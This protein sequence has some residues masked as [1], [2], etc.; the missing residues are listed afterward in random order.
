MTNEEMQNIIEFMIQ[1]QEVFSANLDKL[2]ANLGRLEANQEQLQASQERTQAQLDGLATIV[3]RIGEAV[4]QTQGDLSL[5][6]RI[7]TALV[8]RNGGGQTQ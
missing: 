5:L 8:E 6:S 7:V 3:G 4:E 2:S 1:R